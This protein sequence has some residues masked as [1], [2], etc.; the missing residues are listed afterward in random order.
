MKTI[1][2]L[3]IIGYG[4]SGGFG[5]A[6]NFEVIEAENE[7]AANTYA[8]E[9]ACEYYESYVGNYGLRTVEQIMEEES[10][11]EE[12][13]VQ[14]YSEERESWLDYS[15]VKFSKEAEKKVMGHH[16]RNEFKEITDKL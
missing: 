7:E 1:D 3:F 11:E 9:Q 13:A 6:Q 14:E 10:C 2:D 15:A 16:Y 4:I 8:W 12:E 5:G